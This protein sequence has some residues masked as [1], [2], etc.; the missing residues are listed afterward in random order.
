MYSYV[1]YY[2]IEKSGLNAVS[3]SR[4]IILF[5][6]ILVQIIIAL[7]QRK[8]LCFKYSYLGFQLKGKKKQFLRKVFFPEIPFRHAEI[9]SF[10]LQ[11]GEYGLLYRTSFILQ[12]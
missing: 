4:I 7:K 11:K 8:N 12:I 6:N 5:S 2:N 9:N 1:L 10:L 3:V